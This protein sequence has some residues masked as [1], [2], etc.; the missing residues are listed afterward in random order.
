M[1]FGFG[2]GGLFWLGLVGF[3][4]LRLCFLVFGWCFVLFIVVL[5]FGLVKRFV[6]FV[7]FGLYLLEFSWFGIGDYLL[8]LVVEFGLIF[9][10][11]VMLLVWYWFLFVSS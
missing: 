7:V 5:L 6:G 9:V 8:F 4:C 11:V 1:L 3:G 2:F 10:F